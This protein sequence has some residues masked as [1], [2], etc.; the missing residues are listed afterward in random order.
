MRSTLIFLFTFFL[1]SM[2]S[3]LAVVEFSIDAPSTV[4]QGQPFQIEIYVNV[5]IS[6]T[7]TGADFELTA[8][9]TG[10]PLEV[11]FLSANS[12]NMFQTSQVEITS[13]GLEQSPYGYNSWSFSE[14]DV[15]GG[16]AF[17][18]NSLLATIDA[19][20]YLPGSFILDLPTTSAPFGATVTRNSFFDSSV[21]QNRILVISSPS[22]IIGDTTGDG[23]VGVPELFSFIDGWYL[24][25]IETNY[26][27]NVIDNWYTNGC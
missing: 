15:S 3:T 2:V 9:G 5:P 13:T 7:I 1:V 11:V 23:C 22:V 4:Q 26:L 18:G 20:S 19:V 25:I 6:E 27:F 8:I 16:I 12:N 24:N 17:Q 10:N 21:S 14:M